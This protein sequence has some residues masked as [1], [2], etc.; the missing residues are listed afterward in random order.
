METWE[1]YH[2]METFCEEIPSFRDR[3]RLLEKIRG[4][5]A[6]SRFRDEIYR[7]GIE[8]EWYD[9]KEKCEMEYT[10]NWCV[11]NNLKYYDS[12]KKQSKIIQLETNA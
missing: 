7:L 1:S 10:R 9:W 4:K 2:I 8:P 3:E 5:G 12:S 11:V 6:F